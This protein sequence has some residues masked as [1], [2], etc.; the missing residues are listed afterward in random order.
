MGLRVFWLT[1]IRVLLVITSAATLACHSG[2]GVST[3]SSSALLFTM[4]CGIK[5][6]RGDRFTSILN[7]ALMIATVAIGTVKT[8]FQSNCS[9]GEFKRCWLSNG[10][11]IGS[12][13]VAAFWLLLV[14]YVFIQ[15]SSDIFQNGDEYEVYDFK[16]TGHNSIPMAV[17]SQSPI[18]SPLKQQQLHD[19]SSSHH[20]DMVSNDYNQA[21][22]DPAGYVDYGQQQQYGLPPPNYG[23]H[24]HQPPHQYDGYGPSDAYNNNGG[25]GYY[26]PPES[27]LATPIELTNSQYTNNT[28]NGSHA[29][30][31]TAHIM[32]DIGGVDHRSRPSPPHTPSKSHQVPHTY[33]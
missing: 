12:I 28:P 7:L 4:V 16:N 20:G 13:V 15:R 8:G 22:Y 30:D 24:Q 2:P 10:T 21:Y 11:W 33:D 17:T 1:L 25:Y 18:V 26:V 31:D 3:I 32:A 23:N 29:D 5:S 27:S 9:G 14:L 6:I 19:Q